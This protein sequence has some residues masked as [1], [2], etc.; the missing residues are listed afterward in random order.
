MNPLRQRFL[1]VFAGRVIELAQSGLPR[2]DLDHAAASAFRLAS[3]C[4]D[5]H[6]RRA[7]LYA[8]TEILRERCVAQL[9]RFDGCPLLKDRIG[10]FAMSPLALSRQSRS[11]RLTASS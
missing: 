11:R 10:E 2:I 7:K 5:P 4:R 3:K 9:L 8:A 6:S 1:D